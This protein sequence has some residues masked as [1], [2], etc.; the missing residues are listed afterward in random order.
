MK[1]IAIIKGTHCNSCKLLIED[2]C[3]DMEGVQSCE[4]DLQTGA[5][6]IEHDERFQQNLFKQEVEGLGE[7]KVEFNS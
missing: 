6:V 4:V 5:T 1:T 7:Y 3:R 2:V